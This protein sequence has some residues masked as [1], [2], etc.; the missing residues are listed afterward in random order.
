MGFRDAVWEQRLDLQ[1]PRR[2][3][4]HRSEGRREVN[5]C[6]DGGGREGRHLGWGWGS[7]PKSQRPPPAPQPLWPPAW[8]GLCPTGGACPSPCT[9]RPMHTPPHTGT[10]ARLSPHGAPRCCCRCRVR[11]RAS[12]TQGEDGGCSPA[13]RP[14]DPFGVTWALPRGE[15]LPQP[16][17]SAE[18]LAKRV[19]GGGR[20]RPAR[21]EAAR[22][23]AHAVVFLR[24]AGKELGCSQPPRGTS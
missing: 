21:D 9:P 2:W 18:G 4:G 15:T 22:V 16:P 11:R 10:K 12:S 6:P 1:S 23:Q 14:G 5:E 20:H 24:F 17:A 8:S 13:E 7:F 19:L 3:A